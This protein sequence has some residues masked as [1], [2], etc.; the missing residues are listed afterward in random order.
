MR[1]S[2]FGRRSI[3]KATVELPQ[4]LSG[5]R[6]RQGGVHSGFTSRSTHHD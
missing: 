2:G 4:T 5:Q 6:S 3:F 1:Y